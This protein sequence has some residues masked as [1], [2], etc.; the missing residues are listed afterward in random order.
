MKKFALYILI[1]CIGAIAWSCDKDEPVL[2]LP[3]DGLPVQSKVKRTILIYAAGANSLS[4]YLAN[5][6]T[7]MSRGLAGV[8]L[9]EYRVFL[10]RVQN[11]PMGN[12]PTPQ[13]LTQ[14]VKTSFGV[15]FKTI[16]TY[17]TDYRSTDPERIREV[18]EDV[19]KTSPSDDYGLVFWSHSDAWVPSPGWTPDGPKRSFGQEQDGGKSYYCEIDDLA[20]AVPDDFATF[21]WF[22]S[23]YMA[24]IESAYEFRG[25]CKYYI[26]SALE[27]NAY[28]MP[29]DITLPVLLTEN[30]SPA[31]AAK[32]C[33]DYY[34]RSGMVISMTVLD[35]DKID[36]VADAAAD[37]FR[38]YKPLDN[39]T[40]MQRY[41]RGSIPPLYDFRQFAD[42][43][44]EADGTSSQAL[45]QA[46][47]EFVLY[48]D[49]SDRDFNRRL[50]DKEI[51]SG[52]TCH[53]FVDD[54]SKNAAMYKTLKWYNKVY[55][56]S[57]IP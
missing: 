46:L 18:I 38:G 29:Y 51:Y 12:S 25:K 3:G 35:M 33:F 23:C 52:L 36:G 30:G 8:D 9:S 57:L 34:N 2:P 1:M 41:S 13:T 17:D 50:I 44:A 6:S 24:N 53:A 19:R 37:V 16:K 56:N 49:I 22:D 32:Y 15:T 5:D 55:L 31:L 54:D 27:I 26:G 45:R 14:A 4:S 11:S 48:T 28:G 7:E 10:Y 42:R 40:T 20:E 21:I 47:S 43:V 39:P